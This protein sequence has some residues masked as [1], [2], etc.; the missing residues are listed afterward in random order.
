MR[1][2]LARFVLLSFI[3]ILGTQ[4]WAQDDAAWYQDKPIADIT[5]Q[6]L[7]RVR[8]Q[9]L[10]GIIRPFV[11]KPLS[12]ALY[13]DLQRRLY[14][15]E[16]FEYISGEPVPYK[17]SQ[18]M[19]QLVITVSER[20]GVESIRFEGNLGLKT[21]ELLDAIL[22]KTGKT[23][24][25]TLVSADEISLRNLYLEDGYANATVSSR[26]EDG[27]KLNSRIVIFTISE[28]YRTS[29]RKIEFQGNNFATTDN[30]KRLLGTQEQSLLNQGLFQAATLEKDKEAILKFYRENGYI[31]ARI[32]GVDI[33]TEKSDRERRDFLTITISV[34]EGR[35]WKFGGLTIRGNQIFTT[36]ELLALTKLKP[37][38]PLDLSRF[39]ADYQALM[40]RYY[41]DGYINNTLRLSESRD[42]E[43]GVIS[44]TV[45]IVEYGR[46]YVENIVIKGNTKTQDEVIL[47]ELPIEEG[48]VFSSSAITL[49]I[50]TL[51]SK[52]YFSTIEPQ[53]PAGSAQGLY[54]LILNVEEQ[55]TTT[56]SVGASLSGNEEFPISALF[57]FGDTNFMGTGREMSLEAQA[58]WE[59]QSIKFSLTDPWLFGKRF[60]GGVSLSF[61]RQHLT[62]VAQDILYPVF[63]TDDDEDD[64]AV[65]DPFDGH[66]VFSSDTTY[67]GVDYDAGDDFPDVATTTL[68]DKY[69]LVT[70][71]EYA[72]GS[73]GIPEDYSMEYINWE[74]SLGFNT[75]YRRHFLPGWIGLGAGVSSSLNYV[76]YDPDLYRPFDKDLREN[77]DTV[78]II[79]RVSLN[80]SLDGRDISWDPSIGYYASQAVT[81]TGG[82]LGGARD[83]IRTDTNLQGY[84]TLWNVPLNE[85]VNL[86]TVLAGYSS[87]SVLWPQ[88]F[89]WDTDNFR[90]AS[91]Y[92]YTSPSLIARGW[93]ARKNGEALWNNWMELRTPIVPGLLSFDIYAEAVRMTEDREEMLDFT[94][95]DWMCGFGAGL[96]LA[97]QQ[98]PL[99]LY[100][101]KRFSVENDGSIEWQKGN[102][103]GSDDDN[104]P[105]GLDLI[106]TFQFN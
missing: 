54:D 86:K 21:T 18:E 69:D 24:S 89:S 39:Q 95:G 101:G 35:A 77:L 103:F 10:E 61:A 1:N 98:L 96:R 29:V 3:L 72:G 53:T 17:G 15:L 20:P 104:V 43:N 40:D 49:G 70:D 28:G 5:F 100:L 66:Y 51:Y 47:R 22:L 9:D 45:D 42:E 87:M 14:G 23:V 4:I 6:G 38:S 25:P 36:A 90:A 76:Q 50:Q 27:T 7:Q 19:V 59:E 58:S 91:Y 88:F 2:L 92:L 82:V 106:L 16:D 32:T 94:K 74:A 68:I 81:Y 12:D 31:D 85:D 57:K 67:N 48:D 93:T 62:G 73:S 78:V 97:M 44:Y 55:N 34:N 65:P 52:R 11:G 37:G 84:L 83:Y 80:L 26:I 30:L 75:S 71:Y 13:L 99:R 60:G 79:N 41:K 56:M 33:Q 46:A 102:L 105:D 8:R 64:T 63:D